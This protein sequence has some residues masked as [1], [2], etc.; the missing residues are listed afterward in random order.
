MARRP[1]YNL[2]RCEQGR[3]RTIKIIGDRPQNCISK[4][5]ILFR[6]SDI[7]TQPITQSSGSPFIMAV[8][9]MAVS[10][11]SKHFHRLISNDRS[12]ALKSMY[13]YPKRSP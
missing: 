11:F 10:I 7:N 9:Y 1:V 2:D 8:F 5:F 6:I 13:S 4:T 12:V 3:Y